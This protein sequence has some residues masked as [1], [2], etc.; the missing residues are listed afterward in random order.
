MTSTTTIVSPALPP[1]E[2]P[3]LEE[4]KKL[5]PPGTPGEQ[6]E[7]ASSAS[8]AMLPGHLKP[9]ARQIRQLRAL[10][11][12]AITEMTQRAASKE[13]FSTLQYT[14]GSWYL[15]EIRACKPDEKRW[16][17]S[18]DLRKGIVLAIDGRRMELLLWGYILR[19]SVLVLLWFSVWN[20]LPHQYVEPKGVIWDPIVTIVVSA[21]V[22]GL[23]CRI[24]QIPPL[25]GV[26]WIA[27]MWTSIPSAH[28]LTS[29]I[30]A[31]IPKIATRVGITF[32]L[33]RAGFSTSVKAV[34]PT[35]K[36]TAMLCTLPM[37]LEAITH[38]FIANKLFDYNDT[39]W[40]FAEGFACS[41]VSP[42]IVV[43]AVLF[44]Q[45]QGIG[46]GKGPLTL[47][48]SSCGLETAM[49]VWAV[50]FILGL[51]FQDQSIGLS[52]AL[53]P[54]QFVVGGVLGVVFA[55]IFHFIVEVLKQEADRL[56]DG[57]YSA[58]HFAKTMD[59]SFLIFVMVATCI[60]FFSYS[61]SFAGG[62]AICTV[63]F[64]ATVSHLWVKDGNHELEMQKKHIGHWLSTVWDLLVMPFLFAMVGSQIDINSIFNSEF[65]PK[66]I[67]VVV[68]S[69]AVRFITIFT[70]QTRSGLNTKEKLLVCAGYCG[71][72]GSQASLAPLALQLAQTKF[73]SHHIPDNFLTYTTNF[74]NMAVLYI[75]V[76]APIA[77]ITLVKVGPHACRPPNEQESAALT[78]VKLAASNS[79]GA[80]DSV[81]ESENNSVIL[82]S[83][84]EGHEPTASS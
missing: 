62:G 59:F 26:L 53:G 71:K 46:K 84:S 77:A 75:L 83:A 10:D 31:G 51:I 52:I 35:V 7:I 60:I 11:L 82:P 6:D 78:R 14:G 29:G 70:L 47:M 64:S 24:V 40:A 37:I 16:E 68:C 58:S 73:G 50:N 66:A 44:L 57:H 41:I 79:V 25:I 43:P 69:G 63:L 80:G 61:I 74:R 54:I 8:F 23:L 55:Y 4:M 48:L 67:V 18:F 17:V 5:A 28:F 32:I 2:H 72:A 3:P 56:P 45:D 20:V 34:L 39:T 81:P 12:M 27:I 36:Q 42:A 38:S 30:D 15:P 19:L 1:A 22:G 21:L 13:V 33:A 9:L 76:Y 49:G 65:F